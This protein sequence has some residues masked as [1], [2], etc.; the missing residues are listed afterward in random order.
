MPNVSERP[1]VV[2]FTVSA[3]DLHEFRRSHMGLHIA[4]FITRV[5]QTLVAALDVFPT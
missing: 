4:K 3:S 2:E 5:R 1:S